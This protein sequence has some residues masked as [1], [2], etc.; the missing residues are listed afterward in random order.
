MSTADHAD[1]FDEMTPEWNVHNEDGSTEPVSYSDDDGDLSTQELER[2]YQQAMNVVD[3]ADAVEDSLGLDTSVEEFAPES[4]EQSSGEPSQTQSPSLKAVDSPT[5]LVPK[6]QPI[7]ILEA[8]LFVGGADLTIKKLGRLLGES[9]TPDIVETEIANL[10][11]RY[12]QQQRPYQIDFGEGGYR[13]VLKADFERIRNRVYGLGPKDVKLTQDALEVLAMIAYRQPVTRE[14][15]IEKGPKNASSLLNQ[16]LRRELIILE[17][18][19]DTRNDVEYTTTDRFLQ[20]FGLVNLKD[21]PQP[22]DLAFK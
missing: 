17:R 11:E 1:S 19:G 13:L 4:S 8:A 21:L 10:N 2:L 22:D 15:V 20:V 18:T 3:M 12:E 16:L 5:P 14:V 6:M 7:Q 9:V